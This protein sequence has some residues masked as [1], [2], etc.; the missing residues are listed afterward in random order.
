LRAKDPQFNAGEV[1][2]RDSEGR[3]WAV[4]GRGWS[5]VLPDGDYTLSVFEDGRIVRESNATVDATTRSI[6][7]DD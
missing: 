3:T 1:Q 2:I 6:L 7:V 4:A 5:I